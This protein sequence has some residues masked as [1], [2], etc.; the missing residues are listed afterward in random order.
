MEYIN[1]NEVFIC[2]EDCTSSFVI[3]SNDGGFT[4]EYLYACDHIFVED[5]YFYDQDIAFIT[6]INSIQKSSDG[7]INWY[8]TTINS[9]NYVHFKSIQFPTID[10]GYAVGEGDYETIFKSNNGGE[11]WNPIPSSTTSGMNSVHF[12]DELNG[13]VFGNGGVA[14]KTTTG[15]TVGFEE[16]KPSKSDFLQTFPNP[17]TKLVTIKLNP[18]RKWKNGQIILYDQTGKQVLNY[19]VTSFENEIIISGDLLKSGIYFYQLKT[20]K[21][22]SEAKKMIKL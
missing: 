12:F 7:G 17:F 11:T 16:T 9:S 20:D 5:I 13:L 22:I 21:G 4:W 18:E 8:Q 19:P 10:I 1:E 2:G 15:G 3:K 6:G 14:L